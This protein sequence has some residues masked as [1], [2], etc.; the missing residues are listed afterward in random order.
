VQDIL[1][2][3]DTIGQALED[4]V[5]DAEGD[6]AVALET[7]SANRL[8]QFPGMSDNRMLILL[9]ILQGRVNHQTPIALFLESEPNLAAGDRQL[10]QSWQNS[11]IGIFV[12]IE[13]LADGFVLQNWMSEKQY[14]VKFKNDLEKQQLSRVKLGEIIVASLAPLTDSNWMFWGS[15][16]IL[17]KLGKPKLAVAIGN[18]KQNYPDYLYADAPELLEAAWLSV[19]WYHQQFI[20]FFN[21]DEIVLPGYQLE[22]KLS[23]FQ[24]IVSQNRL[25][26][27]GIDRSR[28][29]TELVQE[30][31]ISAEE[32]DE[33]ASAMGTDAKTVS[34]LLNSPAAGKMMTPPLQL[35]PHLKK[36]AEVTV[37][38]HPRWGQIFLTT[39]TQLKSSLANG[40]NDSSITV[41]ELL[42]QPEY[43]AYIWQ[44]LI[45]AYP[46]QLEEVLRQEMARPDLQITTD[47]THLLQDLG[48]P[49]APQLP[50]IA[51]VPLHLHNL[52]QEAVLEI[53]SKEKIK[54]K[55]RKTK[56]FG[57]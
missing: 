40:N 19:E 42:K 24:E 15:Y 1:T 30:A 25:S 49:T 6:L 10:L 45:D 28:P 12:A 16:T 5:L 21:T 11:I 23:E 46:T 50:E 18:F 13:V 7:F 9:F 41:M 14:E 51:S 17:G 32:I 22:K 43:N 31:G 37:I 54:V 52:F 56:G 34:K 29:L 55:D 4:F 39:Y 3:A 35:P 48:K 33:A 44:R 53:S 26:L 38:S 2:K 20:D 8:A 27:A 36:A 57:A 47:L